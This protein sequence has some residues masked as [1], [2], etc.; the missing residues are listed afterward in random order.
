MKAKNKKRPDLEF[1]KLTMTWGFVL[2]L[3]AREHAGKIPNV[4]QLAM[5][6]NRNKDLFPAGMSL[7][8]A[9]WILAHPDALTDDPMEVE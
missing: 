5:W 3:A 8:Q 2:S 9:K 1:H 7:D 6:A 4:D